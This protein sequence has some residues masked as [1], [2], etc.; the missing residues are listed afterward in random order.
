MKTVG[1]R[2]YIAILAM[3]LMFTS[4]FSQEDKRPEYITVTTM[5]WNMNNDNFDMDTWKA[6]EKEFK[7]KVTSKNEYVQGSSFYMHYFTP[8][9][10]ELI[11][12]QSYPNWE[13]IGKASE[14]NEELIKAA[15]PDEKARGDFEKKRMGYYSDYHS[16]EIYAT[17]PNAK[18]MASPPSKD[19]VLYVRKSHFAFPDDGSQKEFEE[20][21]KM[22]IENVFFKNDLIKAYYP[23]AHAWGSDRT[24]FVEGFLLDNLTDLEAMLDKNDELFKA[25]WSDEKTQKEMGKKMG[26]YFTGKHG[27]YIY[28]YIHGI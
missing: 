28:T 12:V 11:Y 9:N 16:D 26:K 7:D 21:S 24:E 14:R 4:S 10:T 3:V 20:L 27:D 6:V 22:Y 8:D 1:Y 17:M 15:W 13:A 19:M 23:N 2:V 18:L 25:K 5:H